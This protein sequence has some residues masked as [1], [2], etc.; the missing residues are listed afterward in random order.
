M[1]HKHREIFVEGRKVGILKVW[2]N[3]AN[4]VHIIINAF[5]YATGYD[6]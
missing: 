5:D 3:R 4:S 2:V 1:E 6:F